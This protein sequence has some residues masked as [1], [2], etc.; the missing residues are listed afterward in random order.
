MYFKF[1][2]DLLR[3]TALPSLP[4][5]LINSYEMGAG[6]GTAVGTDCVLDD[7]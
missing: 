6:C 5:K 3:F 2:E 7:C 1:A 4:R